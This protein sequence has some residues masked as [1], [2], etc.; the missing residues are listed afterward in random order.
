MVGLWVHVT[1]FFDFLRKKGSKG[2][3]GHDFPPLSGKIIIFTDDDR[4]YKY[5]SILLYFF[6]PSS[7]DFKRFPH[8]I[9]TSYCLPL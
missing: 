3:W 8:N 2:L 5:S 9:N 6:D 7:P 4:I 1:R